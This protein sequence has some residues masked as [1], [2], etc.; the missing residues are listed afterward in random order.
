MKGK[1]KIAIIY[2]LQPP[3]IYG[4]TVSALSVPPNLLNKGYKFITL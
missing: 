3:F 1:V 4:G 2:F